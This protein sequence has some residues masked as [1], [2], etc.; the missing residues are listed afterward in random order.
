VSQVLPAITGKQLIRLFRRDG[1]IEVRRV[2]HGIAFAKV[3]PDGRQRTTIIPDKRSV[4]PPGTLAAILSPKQSELGRDG[5]V[6]LI[7]QHGLR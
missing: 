2:R 6:A 3:G 1:W 4:L 5:L 7:R